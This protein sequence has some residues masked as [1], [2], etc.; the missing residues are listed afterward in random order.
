MWKVFSLTIN[1]ESDARSYYSSMKD[2]KKRLHQA[3]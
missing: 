1:S 3:A 2:I